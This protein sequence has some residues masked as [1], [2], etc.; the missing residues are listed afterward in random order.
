MTATRCLA[1]LKFWINSIVVHTLNPITNETAPIALIGTRKDKISNPADHHRISTI[2]YEHF[3]SSL[4]WPSVIE[5]EFAVGTNGRS[6]LLCFYPVDNI[7]GRSDPTVVSCM[8]DIERV[9]D[10]SDYVHRKQPLVYLKT[11][12]KLATLNKNSLSFDE[13]AG[14]AVRCGVPLAG[15]TDMLKLFHEMGIVM[16]HGNYSLM[17]SLYTVVFIPTLTCGIDVDEPELRDSVI[18]DPISFFVKP[19]TMIICKVRYL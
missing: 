19:A 17:I 5:N 1:T 13:A 16:F 12:D 3:S 2:L 15:V 10:Q 8:K 14:V 18:L 7:Q 6:S 4:A 11:I 9:I